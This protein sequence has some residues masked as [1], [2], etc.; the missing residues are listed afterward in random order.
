MAIRFF[1]LKLKIISP[2][3]HNLYV[4]PTGNQVSVFSTDKL[5]GA[6]YNSP[7]IK[8]HY[9]NT[10][11]KSQIFYK[12]YNNNS[13]TYLRSAFHSADSI[14]GISAD[15]TTLDEIQDILSDH[16]SVIEQCM[17]HSLAK[18]KDMKD[19]I[20]NLP[21]HM[22]NAK[23]Y[24]GTPKTVE[25]TLENYW[26]KSTQNEWLI[27]CLHCNKWNYINEYNVGETCLICNKCDR[28]IFYEDGMWVSMN[29]SGFIQGYR[30]PQIVLNWINDRTNPKVWQINVIHTRATY[31]TE[32]FYNEILALPY[33]NAKNPLS[34]ANIMS[35]C[36]DYKVMDEPD[37]VMIKDYKLFAG[38]D[39]GKGDTASGTSYTTLAIGGV[40]RN[41]FK[42]LLIKKYTGKM[43][44]A[45]IQ[46]EDIL[47][48]IRKFKVGF[49]IADYGDG[50]TSNATMHKALGVGHFAEMYEHASLGKKMKWDGGKGL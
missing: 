4:A 50:R 5:N 17:S 33:A 37:K 47:Q 31:S 32:K 11:T 3:Y 6:Y 40:I 27:K 38:I 19:H 20:P 29:P 43:S 45:L 42:I 48:T 13:K 14:R 12:E 36:K 46:I 23:I 35:A 21:M 30:L 28:P 44:E 8:K 22:F 26:E 25:N 34:R 39:W 2:N 15:M 18:W 10:K 7:I 9:L 16:V 24:S 41:R 1:L 49:T